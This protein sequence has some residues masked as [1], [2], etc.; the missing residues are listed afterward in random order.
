MPFLKTPNVPSLVNILLRLAFCADVNKNANIPLE[1]ISMMIRFFF[2]SFFLSLFLSFSHS[3]FFKFSFSSYY[4][5][6]WTLFI[7]SQASSKRVRKSQLWKTGWDWRCR[8]QV[9]IWKL[10]KRFSWLSLHTFYLKCATA[11]A[12]EV[13]T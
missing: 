7:F 6:Y 9:R 4:R 2:L 13:L 1:Q 11:Q 3:L 5:L 8:I 10:K 12:W